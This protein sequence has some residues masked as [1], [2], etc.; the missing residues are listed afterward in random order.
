MSP[1]LLAILS[2]LCFT[3]GFGLTATAVASVMK[4]MNAIIAAEDVHPRWLQEVRVQLKLG[5]KGAGLTALAWVFL[6]DAARLHAQ[7]APWLGFTCGTLTLVQT[8]ALLWASRYAHRD[9]AEQG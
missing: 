9:L 7:I 6:V 8:S 5:L 4:I 3:S 1:N 2:A